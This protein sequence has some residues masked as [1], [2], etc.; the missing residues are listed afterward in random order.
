MSSKFNKP[1]STPASAE[2]KIPTTAPK[3]DRDAPPTSSGQYA[4]PATPER[5]DDPS[6]LKDEKDALPASRGRYATPATP[7]HDNESAVKSPISE[8]A[9]TVRRAPLQRLFLGPQQIDSLMKSQYGKKL[10]KLPDS[11]ATVLKQDRE[12]T[13]TPIEMPPS[14]QSNNSGSFELLSSKRHARVG[15]MSEGLVSFL[16]P[17]NDTDS[18]VL[19]ATQVNDNMPS[20]Q[21]RMAKIRAIAE[22]VRHRSG[23]D[24]DLLGALQLTFNKERMKDIFP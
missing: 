17:P 11:F 8:S 23:A 4:V 13:P 15:A 3:S 9:S 7:G 14:V 2:R 21:S 10:G 5:D 18:E 1:T 19:N 16:S 12:E 6:S 24:D 20:S 22:D